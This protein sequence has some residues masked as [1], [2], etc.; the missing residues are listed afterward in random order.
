MGR[1]IDDIERS[2]AAHIAV[3]RHDYTVI[4]YL[5]TANLLERLLEDVP[6]P[7][8]AEWA[9]FVRRC[10]GVIVAENQG[11]LAKYAEKD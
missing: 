8:D 2:V 11:W 3:K 1:R 4:T 7:G 5:A 6:A 10:E 9:G